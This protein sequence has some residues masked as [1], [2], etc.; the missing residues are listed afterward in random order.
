MPAS[1]LA[2]FNPDREAI[3][4]A[5]FTK[6]QA[7]YAWKNTPER[8][9]KLWS[10]VPSEQR[11]AMFQFEGHD[12]TWDW[13]NA[14]N[15]KVVLEASIFIYTDCKDPTVIG[16]IQL[17]EVLNAITTALVPG[18]SDIQTGRQTLGGLVHSARIQGSVSRVPGDIDGDGMA[19]VP[20]RILVNA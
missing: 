16:A 15:P 18:V 3:Y 11:P 14:S 6:M 19:I 4:A 13:S 7:A 17:N 8:R 12:E 10:D 5:L 2:F 9:V 20:V 1:P